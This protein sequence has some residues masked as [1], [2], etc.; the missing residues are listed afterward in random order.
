MNI[1]QYSPRISPPYAIDVSLGPLKSSTQTTFRSLQP[2]LPGSLVG[3]RPTDRPTDHAIRSVTIGK[4][5]REKAKFCHCLRLQQVFIGPVDSHIGST[6]AISSYI[7]L[8][9]LYDSTCCSVCADTLQ[10]S[11]KVSVLH[12]HTST[13]YL[14]I[15][16]IRCLRLSDASVICRVTYF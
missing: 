1:I 7:Q 15:P 8:R 5:H 12:R 13:A 11:L 10:Y 16:S 6:S 14:T 3:D 4:A 2:F 9:Q